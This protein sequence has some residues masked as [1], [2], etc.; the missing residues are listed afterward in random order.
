MR[1]F[2]PHPPRHTAL[3]KHSHDA[4]GVLQHG[5]SDPDF[6]NA[7]STLVIQDREYPDTHMWLREVFCMNLPAF[8]AEFGHQFSAQELYEAWL[9]F[10]VIL[11][12]KKDGGIRSRTGK[13]GGTNAAQ[14]TENVDPHFEN[15]PRETKTDSGHLRA[16]KFPRKGIVIMMKHQ[17]CMRKAAAGAEAAVGAVAMQ[18]PRAKFVTYSRQPLAPKPRDASVSRVTCD[19][20][21]L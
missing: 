3:K 15:G 20:R 2:T 16:A 6:A 14:R 17:L 18:A 9:E 1:Y 19:M 4:E 5:G 11:R 7:V 12:P 8:F 21:N 10:P 13:T